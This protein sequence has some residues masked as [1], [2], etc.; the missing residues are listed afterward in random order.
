M[1]IPSHLLQSIDRLEPLPLTAQ[2]LITEIRNPDEIHV[3]RIVDIIQYD[4]AAVSNLL[5][6][7]NSAAYSGEMPITGVREA[8]V[9]LG[10]ARLLDII[11]GNYLKQLK[12]SAPLYDL[13]ENELWL[14]STAASL[15]VRAIER[16]TRN[17]GI[18]PM[19]CVAA[20][21]HDI[22]KLIMVRYLEADVNSLTSLCREQGITFVEA[23]RQQFGCDHA[24]IG[25]VIGR[26]WGFPEEIASAIE[27][28]H[29]F[30]EG[31]PDLMLDLVILANV[32]A[33]SIGAGLGAEGLNMKVDLSGCRER[34]GLSCEGFERVC[35]QTAVDLD[36]VRKTAGYIPQ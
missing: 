24:T 34:L 16:E 23:E 31:N 32:A 6:V 9:R 18:P 5:R 20:L 8:A 13:S 36:E 15:A 1:T 4:Q 11:L 25:G 26:K 22:G 35:A 28:H 17:W 3:N 33:K 19:A 7:A 27:R 14:H 12:I 10:T 2:R 21:L 30:H 29:E